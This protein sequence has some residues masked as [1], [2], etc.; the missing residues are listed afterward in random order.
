MN[1]TAAQQMSSTMLSSQ[2]HGGSANNLPVLASQPQ[3][4]TQH[5][6][7]ANMPNL[8]G[9]FKHVNHPQAMNI[10][11]QHITQAASGIP[12]NQQV[13]FHADSSQASAPQLHHPQQQPGQQQQQI[14][15]LQLAQGQQQ[16]SQ[17]L[18]TTG[19]SQPQQQQQHVSMITNTGIPQQVQAG[20][21]MRVTLPMNVQNMSGLQTIAGM[22][23]FQQVQVISR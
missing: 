3:M 17:G 1:L 9:P 5:Q 13:V 4:L 19:T 14:Q 6:I 7:L 11:G 10:A 2:A 15:A 18:Q 23:Q 8:Q 22:P 12:S 20:S 21:M 16:F